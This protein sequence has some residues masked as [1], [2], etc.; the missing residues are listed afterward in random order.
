ML[1]NRVVGEREIF[2]SIY[3]TDAKT[4][5]KMHSLLDWPIYPLACARRNWDEMM[6]K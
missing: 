4:D 6:L 2:H 3:F 5:D 1:I